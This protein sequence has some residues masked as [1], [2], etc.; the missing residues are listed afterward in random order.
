MAGPPTLTAFAPRWRTG[1]VTAL[2]A[3]MYASRD[4]SAM[5]ILADALQDA[6]C[7]SNDILNHCRD[8]IPHV[9]GCWVVDLVLGALPSEA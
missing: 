3:Q 4:F 8:T 1:T 2:A 5:P 9:R 7:D 6:G